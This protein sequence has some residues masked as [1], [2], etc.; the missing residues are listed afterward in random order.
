MAEPSDNNFIDATERLALGQNTQTL[1]TNFESAF[2][3]EGN[4]KKSHSI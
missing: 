3:T 2:E 1:T 4:L